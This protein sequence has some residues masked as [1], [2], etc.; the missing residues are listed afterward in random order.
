MERTHHLPLVALHPGAK[1]LFK[2]WPP[3]HFA[4]LGKQ[5]ARQLGCRIFVTG[6]E[7]EKECVT[8]IASQIDGAIVVLDLPLR[9]MAALMGHMHLI[10]TNDTGPMHVA[11]AM[12]T[13]TI[14]LFSPTNPAL[15]GP[16]PPLER[17]S[18]Q[19]LPPAPPV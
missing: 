7:S 18:S 15:C 4:Q 5:L 9:K 10:I 13:P 3:E 12:K 19:N 2:Q 11:F 8:A 6:T 16:Y 14:A 17:W 1:D